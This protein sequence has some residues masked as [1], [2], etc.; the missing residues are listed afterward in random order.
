MR[1][2]GS[3]SSVFELRFATLGA[4]LPAHDGYAY[5]LAAGLSIAHLTALLDLWLTHYGPSPEKA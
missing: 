3:A 1:G 4:G 2:I 5:K